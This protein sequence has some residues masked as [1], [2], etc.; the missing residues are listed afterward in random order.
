MDILS[1]ARLPKFCLLLSKIVHMFVMQGHEAAMELK[2][3]TK[4]ARTKKRAEKEAEKRKAAGEEEEEL[5]KVGRLA[6][7]HATFWLVIWSFFLVT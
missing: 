6:L 1:I 7:G 3:Q 5:V 2:N 4:E